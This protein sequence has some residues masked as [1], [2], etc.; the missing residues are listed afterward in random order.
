[1]STISDLAKRTIKTITDNSPA[2]LTGLGAAGVVSTAYLASRAAFRA[3]SLITAE[4][5]LDALDRNSEGEIPSFK[6][7]TLKYWKM[8]IP[9]AAVG[10]VTVVCIIGA[11]SISSRRNA[12]LISVYTLTESAFKEYKEK[13]VEQ[14]GTNQE[15]KVRDSVAQDTVD[16]HP[17]TE[18]NMILMTN[19]DVL[20]FDKHTGRYFS[21]NMEKLRKVE[22]D[23]NYELLNGDGNISLNE[24]YHKI[25]LASVATGEDL[26]WN[27]NDKFELVYSATISEDKKPCMVIQFKKDPRPNFYKLW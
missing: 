18:A 10:T 16:A 7:L 21:S 15:K 3:G 9:A 17:L 25:G 19:G 24:F 5:Y 13:V 27:S 14:I 22:N 20:C 1:M 23:V 12:A 2:I 11:N 26:G 8:F 4:I 6:E